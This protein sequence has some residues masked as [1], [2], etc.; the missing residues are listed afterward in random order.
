MLKQQMDL[1]TNNTLQNEKIVQAKDLERLYFHQ[2]N[3]G[4][5]L[6]L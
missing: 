1:V 4:L 2:L 5:Q 3:N 6:H